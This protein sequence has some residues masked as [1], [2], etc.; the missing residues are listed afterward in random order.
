MTV[1]NYVRLFLG[2]LSPSLSG[3]CG[4][5]LCLEAR[6]CPPDPPVPSTQV[7]PRVLLCWRAPSLPC[8]RYKILPAW[9]L[10]GENGTKLSLHV[11]I[12][13]NRAISGEQGEFY[14][15]N[16]ARAGMQGEF[17]TGNAARAGVLGEFC[18]GSWAVRLVLG[19]ICFVV[20]PSV[21]AVAGF[22]PPTGA[23]S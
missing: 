8:V 2:W 9:L 22:P 11:E 23:P 14:T 20:A 15:G 13:P 6:P 1:G 4:Q 5:A 18:T 12:A 21:C 16:A 17:Y 3:C 7:G 10:G 19:E